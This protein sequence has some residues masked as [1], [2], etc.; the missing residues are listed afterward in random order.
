MAIRSPITQKWSNRVRNQTLLDNSKLKESLNSYHITEALKVVFKKNPELRD[1][2]QIK[3]VK[4]KYNE[5]NPIFKI[6]M[7]CPKEDRLNLIMD[8]EEAILTSRRGEIIDA[9]FDIFKSG[10]VETGETTFFSNEGYGRFTQKPMLKPIEEIVELEPIEEIVE[11]YSTQDTSSFFRTGELC[12]D[13]SAY[14]PPL[15]F[16]K[17]EK[18]KGKQI[19]SEIG[20]KPEFDG[21]PSTQDE[22]PSDE[23]TYDIVAE[24]DKEI[25][26]AAEGLEEPSPKKIKDKEVIDDAEKLEVS[27]DETI[28]YKRKMKQPSIASDSEHYDKSREHE[29]RKRLASDPVLAAV[30]KKDK[31]E[32]IDY[33]VEEPEPIETKAPS[34]GPEYIFIRRGDEWIEHQPTPAKKREKLS[35]AGLEKREIEEIRKALEDDRDIKSIKVGNKKLLPAYGT[36]LGTVLVYHGKA[37]WGTKKI[38]RKEVNSIEKTEPTLEDAVLE[39]KNY[40][41][42]KFEGQVE[43]KKEKRKGVI[44]KTTAIIGAAAIVGTTLAG[45][46]GLLAGLIPKIPDNGNGVTPDTNYAPTLSAIS[47]Q[48]VLAGNELYLEVLASDPNLGEGDVLTFSDDSPYLDITKVSANKGEIK[49]TPTLDDLGKHLTNITVKDKFGKSDTKAFNITVTD[50]PINN[51]TNLP[52]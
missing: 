47:D 44:Y 35:Y 43:E 18:S 40:F 42:D 16:T 21:S 31:P 34:F 10:I 39:V 1:V 7:N 50:K 24:A 9:G 25:A 2:F 51:E 17:K 32:T 33:Y 45:L 49:W 26:D 29:D 6:V 3:E 20:E 5:D 19:E 22:Q 36:N 48:T 41:D 4:S 38:I 13:T 23:T 11:D 28:K 12:G 30:R 46:Y 52:P 15:F 37:P 14:V 8:L 27:D